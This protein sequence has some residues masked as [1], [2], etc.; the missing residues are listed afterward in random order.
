MDP[1][2]AVARSL[3]IVAPSN[4]R[5]LAMKGSTPVAIN[6]APSPFVVHRDITLVM[7]R[8]FGESGLISEQDVCWRA[9]YESNG[10]DGKIVAQ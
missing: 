4:C 8:G 9:V 7:C 1:A 3:R 6:R 2:E 5:P 10:P